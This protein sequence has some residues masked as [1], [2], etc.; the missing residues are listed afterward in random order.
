VPTD[1]QPWRAW[2]FGSVALL[3]AA[4]TAFYI[5]RL[6]FMTFEGTKRWT[7]RADGSHQHPHE[8]SALMTVPMIILAIGSFA[9]GGILISG[10]RFP[11]W[12]EPSVGVTE[13]GE[14]VIPAPVLV[15][16]SL[17]VVAVGLVIAWRRYAVAPVP[18]TPPLG[19]TLT[20]AARKDLYQ[21][22]VNDGVLVVPGQVLTRSLVYGDRALVD[23]AV[24][25]LAKGAVA[26]GDLARRPQ[27]GYVRSYA[28]TMLLGLVAL[29]VVVLAL[30][31]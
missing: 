29:V 18:T 24:S 25:G 16:L 15:A 17:L 19:T 6:F 3:G 12:L 13:H 27:T 5:G 21:D 1:G 11:H 7:A 10:S 26:S 31:S 14:P 28:S 2:L 8:A 23:G 30:Q 22:V 4:I 20:R 9:L